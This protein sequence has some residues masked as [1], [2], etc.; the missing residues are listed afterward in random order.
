MWFD[1]IVVFNVFDCIYV[2][3][4][5]CLFVFGVCV[6]NNFGQIELGLWIFVLLLMLDDLLYVDLYC[7]EGVFVLGCLIDLCIELLIVDVQGQLCVFGEFGYLF[8]CM[9]YVMYGYLL[10]DGSLWWFMML[11][12][13]DLVFCCDDGVVFWVGCCDEMVK[14]NGWFINVSLLYQYFDV[15]DDIVKSYF[16]VDL[17]IGVLMVFVVFGWMLVSVDVNFKVCILSCYWVV[18][19][20]YLCIV[21][22]LFVDDFLVMCMG[23]ILLCFLCESV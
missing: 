18:F 21:D 23:K 10:F 20:L 16:F 22:V 13:G 6:W 5:C 1:G 17:Q 11:E 8:Y 9:L 12:F 4:V 19:L 7:F 14:C 2:I 15:F 3:Q